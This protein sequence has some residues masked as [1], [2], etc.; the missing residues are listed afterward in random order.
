MKYH[1]VRYTISLSW[2]KSIEKDMARLTV[3]L[4]EIR[5]KHISVFHYCI[6][7]KQQIVYNMI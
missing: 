5:L 4:C 3:S 6:E 1:R 2:F 7:K